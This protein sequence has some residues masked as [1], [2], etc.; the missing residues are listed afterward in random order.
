MGYLRKKADG[1]YAYPEHVSGAR[2][3]WKRLLWRLGFDPLTVRQRLRQVEREAADW[4]RWGD[5]S[6][7]ATFAVW[8]PRGVSQV[9][10]GDAIQAKR[11]A[12]GRFPPRER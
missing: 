10:W 4:K 1:F 9:E 11:S 5:E 2:G 6:A 7:T 8:A 12:P 3:A